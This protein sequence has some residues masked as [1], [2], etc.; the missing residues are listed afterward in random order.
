[1]PEPSDFPEL[2]RRV[3]AGDEDAAAELNR[4]FEPF[5]R[6]FVRFR[7]RLR[8]TE[9]R[10]RRLIDS[11]DVCQSVFLSL[12]RGL[13]AGRFEL[14]GPDQLEKLLCTMARLKVATHARRPGVTRRVVA[15]A[16]DDHSWGQLV[17]AGP[18]P[19]QQ[20]AGRD[21]LDTVLGLLSNDELQL[22][23]RRDNKQEWAE[24]AA[25]LGGTPEA[26]RKKLKRALI[27]VRQEVELDDVFDV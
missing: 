18:G 8:T 12:Y 23:V 19:D 2:I 17:D 6:R 22:L 4:R 20:A 9:D 24:I 27:R 14:D 11:G 15:D 16:R 10:L 13:K 5:I 26:H 25:V 21:L 1:M 7:M 3:R